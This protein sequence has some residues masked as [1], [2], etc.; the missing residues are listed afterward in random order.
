M[1]LPLDAIATD[2]LPRDRA[3]LD[4]AALAELRARSCATGCAPRSR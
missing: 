4:P 3:A 2:A 1:R